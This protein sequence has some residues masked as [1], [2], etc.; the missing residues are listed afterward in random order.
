MVSRAFFI[1]VLKPKLIIKIGVLWEGTNMFSGVPEA[2]KLLREKG[3]R[4]FFVTNNSTKSRSSFLK[5]FEGFGIQAELV[6]V[7]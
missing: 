7:P 4:V 6:S 3:K 5:K 2:M 1:D